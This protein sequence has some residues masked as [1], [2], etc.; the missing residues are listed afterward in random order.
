MAGRLEADD[1]VYAGKV[2]HGFTSVTAADL[3]RGLRLWFREARHSSRKIKKPSAV[4]VRPILLAEV[5]DR[6]KS[7][8]GKLRHPH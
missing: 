8:E 3:R 7:A 4:W 1:L 6:A 5:E 2:D